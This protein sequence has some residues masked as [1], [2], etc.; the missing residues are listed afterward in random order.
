MTAHRHA[1]SRRICCALFVAVAACSAFAAYPD[2]PIRIVVP[3]APGGGNDLLARTVGQ[4]IAALLGQPVVIENRAG[5]GGNIGTEFVAR[6]PGDGYTLLMASN[7][8]V[9]SPLLAPAGFDAMKDLTPVGGVADVQFALVTH[10]GL[11]VRT[12]EE[13][14]AYAREN[15][16]GLNHG[17]P[18]NGTPQHLAAE[19]LNSMAAITLTHVPYKGSAPAIADLLAGQAQLAFATVPSIEQHVKSKRLTALAVSGARRSGA[20]PAVPTMAEAG[21]PGYEATTWFA[22]MAP[23]TTP[24]PVLA[25]L[26]EAVSQAL[27]DPSMI[28]KLKSQGFEP[29]FRTRSSVTTLMKADADKWAR[30]IKAARIKAD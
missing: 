8:M 10:P 24:A 27:S 7:Q 28:D 3:Y 11:P 19:L 2:R 1:F 20:L 26:G 9:I 4:R 22:L 30:I 16:T 6:A 29:G 14:I 12:V 21:V 25:A 17:T 23:G 13:F 5:A 18:G 15:K